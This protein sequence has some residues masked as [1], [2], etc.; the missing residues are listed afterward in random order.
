MSLESVIS[1]TR[2]IGTIIN[3]LL[4]RLQNRIGQVPFRHG[5]ALADQAFVSGSRFAATVILGR[6]CGAEELGAYGLSFTFLVMFACVQESLITLPYTVFWA[7]RHP[8]RRDAHA[9]SI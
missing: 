9:G 7:R 6:T 8:R 2:V 5:L 1:K 4:D 3:R